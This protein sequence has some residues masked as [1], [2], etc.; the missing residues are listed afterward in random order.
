VSAPEEVAVEGGE[1]TKGQWKLEP[2]FYTEICDHRV[3]PRHRASF[4]GIK[5]TFVDSVE[6]LFLF[7][8]SGPNV[9]TR[10]LPF[11]LKTR[12]LDKMSVLKVIVFA[13][14]RN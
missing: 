11:A 12:N 3:E 9:I 4:L 5:T 2:E 8:Y 14:I 7:Q 13:C 6:F 10:R 1:V